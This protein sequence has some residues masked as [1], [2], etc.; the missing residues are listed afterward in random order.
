G[1][2]LLQICLHCQMESENGNFTIDDV[3]K[4]I[5]EKLIRRHPHVFGETKVSG[6]AEVLE[7]W[8]AI[9]SIE[10]PERISALSGISKSQPA[11]MSAA[12][13]SKKAVKTGFEWPNVE[14]L[15]DCIHSELQEF[16]EAVENNNK[17]EMEDELGD[18]LFSIVNLA[19]WHKI[20]PEIALLKA[21]K[22]F[23]SRFEMMEQLAQKDLRDY[24]LDEYDELWKKAKVKLGE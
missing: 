3:A 23:V 4:E 13:I 21:N 9:K 12:E 6:T 8:D 5:N 24:N 22:K 14:S 18:I 19:R 17:N 20:S 10:K 1:D 15:W 11:L 16:R 7:N 2:V